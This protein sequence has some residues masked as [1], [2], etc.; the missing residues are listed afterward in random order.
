[1]AEAI[2]DQNHITVALGV[3]SADSSVT[4][5]ITIDNVTGRLLTDATG[6]VGTVTSV[7]VA[8][9]NGLAGTV[10]TATSTPA[11]TLSTSI[12]GVL[13]GN[14]TAISAAVNS[15]LPVMTATV[16]GAVPTPP[17]NTTDFLRGDGTFAAPAGAGTVTSVSVVTANG[18]SGSVATATST[19]A[20]T[21]T[22]G[23]I[24]PSGVTVSDLTAS[25]LVATDASKG[26]ES[27]A[28]ATYPSL[29]EISYVKGLTSA[30]QT[31]LGTKMAN[32]MTTGGDVIYGGGSGAPTRLANG[33]NGQVLTSAGTTDAPTWETPSAGGSGSNSFSWFIS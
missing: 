24:T 20:I 19:P 28:V 22:L 2:R 26:L 8:S 30:I 9:A 5:P 16:G 12:T 32:P 15:D 4:L 27:L 31:Q 1:M 11:I 25:E 18:V 7:S 13:L 10:A 23:A 3:S 17:N 6:A 33:T 29:T 14:G 21:L